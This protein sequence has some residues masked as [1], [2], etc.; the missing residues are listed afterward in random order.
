MMNSHTRKRIYNR[1]D[2][3]VT[4]ADIHEMFKASKHFTSGKH[5]VKIRNLGTTW[6][7]DDSVGDTLACIVFDGLVVT[8]MLCFASQT[9]DD[10]KTWSLR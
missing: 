3:I 7:L 5:Y 1:L 8:A 6:Y 9:W 4:D 10:G 2:G